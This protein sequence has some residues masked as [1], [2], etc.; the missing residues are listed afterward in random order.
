MEVDKHAEMPNT[1]GLR[2]GGMS[3]IDRYLGVWILVA[4]ALGLAL[5]RVI[6]GLGEFLSSM[7]V[8][9]ISIPIALGILVMMCPP[10]AKVR[11]DKT[12][13]IAADKRLMAVSLILNWIVGPAVMFT[14]AWIF[15]MR[16]AGTAHGA[17][18]CWFGA[19]YR[20]GFGVVRFV[21]R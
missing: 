11:Y 20:D 12:A 17:H 18:H 2:H 13:K 8:G 10:L 14:L 19:L 16:P 15:L 6:P 1:S 5:G 21:M 7:E 4:M 9:G 3:F